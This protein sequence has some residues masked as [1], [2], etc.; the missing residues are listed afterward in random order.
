MPPEQTMQIAIDRIANYRV[1]VE[2]Y[3][4]DDIFSFKL[5]GPALFEQRFQ[6]FREQYADESTRLREQMTRARQQHGYGP[7]GDDESLMHLNMRHVYDAGRYLTNGQC[8]VSIRADDDG[9]ELGVHNDLGAFSGFFHDNPIFGRFSLSD[10]RLER[11]QVLEKAELE[12]LNI[13]SRIEITRIPAEH[14]SESTFLEIR[15]VYPLTYFFTLNNRTIARTLGQHAYIDMVTEE[16]MASFKPFQV[17]CCKN[18]KYF[19][20]SGMSYDMS[21]GFSGYCH[22]VIEQLRQTYPSETTTR[23][24]NWCSKFESR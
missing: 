20:F 21:G 18:C 16:V 9:F 12:A 11:Y 1:E 7:A 22:W 5:A 14:E 8:I 15:K 2:K 17:K 19:K 3:Y 13:L 4:S 23:I 6:R 24:W 10:T